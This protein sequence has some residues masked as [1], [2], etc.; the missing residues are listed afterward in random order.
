MAGIA[1]APCREVSQMEKIVS[2]AQNSSEGAWSF[3][4]RAKLIR[5]NLLGSQAEKTAAEPP[6]CVPSGAVNSLIESGRSTERA[7]NA[8]LEELAQIEKCLGL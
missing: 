2:N 6:Q 5:E 3:V 1:D 4:R 7:F 8:L